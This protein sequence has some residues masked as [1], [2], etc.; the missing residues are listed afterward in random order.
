MYQLNEEQT[1]I[2]RQKQKCITCEKGFGL[3]DDVIRQVCTEKLLNFK[4]QKLLK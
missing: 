4:I 2:S 3:T 1:T